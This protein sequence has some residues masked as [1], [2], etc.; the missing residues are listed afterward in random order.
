MLYYDP[1]HADLSETDC[2][3]IIKYYTLKRLTI[4]ISTIRL[5]ATAVVLNRC[6]T[7][8]ILLTYF[9]VAAAK[10]RLCH[11]IKKKCALIW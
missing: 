4:C 2:V 7:R 1:G 10:R 5:T 6:A 8:A 11:V 9:I 3:E